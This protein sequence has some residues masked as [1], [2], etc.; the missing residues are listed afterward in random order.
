[1]R[2]SDFICRDCVFYNPS[3]KVEKEDKTKSSKQKPKVKVGCI[4]NG[5][6]EGNT[7]CSKI[8]FNYKK[9]DLYDDKQRKILAN[10]HNA[11][12]VKLRH[13]KSNKS[14]NNIPTSLIAYN[15][16]KT[17]Y[18]GFSLG[19]IFY[20]KIFQDDYLSNYAKVVVLA[21]T[22]NYVYVQGYYKDKLFY[23]ELYPSSLLTESQFLEKRKYLIDNNLIEDPNDKLRCIKQKGTKVKP[24]YKFKYDE[25][26]SD[27]NL[28]EEYEKRMKQ[29]KLEKHADRILKDNPF[30]TFSSDFIQSNGFI[31]EMDEV[32]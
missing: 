29:K 21:S 5:K 17:R 23:C 3:A 11:D 9:I 12:L 25:E 22:K 4:A 32:D 10:I 2:A 8:L 1:M 20:I 24:T 19:E 16:I 13:W 27:F 6:F 18:N 14:V 28:K 26:E 15:E 30:G 7:A 31:D